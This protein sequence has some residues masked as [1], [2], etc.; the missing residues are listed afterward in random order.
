MQGAVTDAIRYNNLCSLTEAIS[1]SSSSVDRKI[2]NEK[3]LRSVRIRLAEQEL[4]NY[5]LQLMEAMAAIRSADFI[6]ILKDRRDR[7][8]AAVDQLLN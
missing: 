7:A 2:A 1:A 3:D 8:K 6:Q 4:Q 5:E